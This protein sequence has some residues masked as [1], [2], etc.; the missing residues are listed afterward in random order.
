MV[1]S[2]DNTEGYRLKGL[3]I[4]QQKAIQRQRKVKK[5]HDQGLKIKQI[6]EHLNTP[7]RTTSRDIQKI[8]K[9]PHFFS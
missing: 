6:C 9:N 4:R 5:L 7:L 3:K 8:K 1:F 2:K